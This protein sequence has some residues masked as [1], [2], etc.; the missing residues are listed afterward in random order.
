LVTKVILETIADYFLATKLFYIS[1]NDVIQ[2]CSMLHSINSFAE[3]EC[4]DEDNWLMTQNRA[5]TAAAVEQVCKNLNCSP[6]S[7]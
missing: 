3:N 1:R 2:Q 4:K 7:C 5:L 6:K